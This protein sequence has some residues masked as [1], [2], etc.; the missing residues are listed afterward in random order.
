MQRAKYFWGKVAWGNVWHSLLNVAVPLIVLLLVRL[1]LTILALATILASKW[2]V[3]AVQPRHWLANFRTNSSDLIV[4][5]SFLVLLYQASSI[6]TNLLWTGFYIIWLTYVKPKSSELWV[7]IQAILTHFLG[8]SALFWLADSL[9][10][11]IVVL[12]AWLIGLSAGRHF[13][14]HFEE[15]LIRVISFGWALVVAEIVWISNR[16]LIIYPLANDLVVPQV[17]IIIT[18]IAYVLGSLYYLSQKGALKRSYA[19]QYVISGCAII[20]MIILLTN[21]S[22]DR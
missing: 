10:E 15:A 14:S 17:A 13:I 2:R 8:L 7:G 4:N 11:S 6:A 22:I 18:M 1:N 21:W 3:V 9:N 5:L 12:T 19:R 20:L 16:W